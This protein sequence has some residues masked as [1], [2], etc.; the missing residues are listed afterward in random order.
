MK[1]MFTA[2]RMSSIAMRMTM[3]FR[4]FRKMPNTPRVNRIAATVR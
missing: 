4:R 1:L 2:S 3:T